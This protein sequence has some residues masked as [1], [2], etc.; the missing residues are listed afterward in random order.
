MKAKLVSIIPILFLFLSCSSSGEEEV[1][2]AT[3]PETKPE[4]DNTAFGVYKGIIMGMNGSLKIVINNG[5]NIAQA[6]IYQNNK[7]TQ[8]L[9]TTYNFTLGEDITNAEFSNSQA[10]L[11]F[12]VS[13]NG[14]NPIISNYTYLG[15]SN[16]QAF[17]IRELSYSQVLCYEGTFKGDDNGIFKCMVNNGVLTGYVLSNDSNDTYST[18]AVITDNQ[19][20]A[21]FGNVSSGASFDGQITTIGCAGNWNNP[22]FGESGTF[23]GKRTL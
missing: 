6:Y 2:Y 16:P 1:V 17:A 8:T 9:T 22:T 13:A 21:V 4:F 18:S 5:D 12:S 19:F 15:V 3:V 7:I 10:S 14:S 11:R 23:R 20:N